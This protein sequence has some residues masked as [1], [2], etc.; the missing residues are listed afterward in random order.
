MNLGTVVVL[1]VLIAVVGAIIAS[2]V[3]AHKQGRYI[4]CDEC[5]GC[6]AHNPDRCPCAEEMVKD[7]DK[8]M[9][10]AE[11]RKPS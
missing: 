10:E 11:K 5:G 8:A 9:R 4:A 3:R 1:V 6:S 7:I 2:W